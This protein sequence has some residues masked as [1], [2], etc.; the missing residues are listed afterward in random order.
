MKEQLRQHGFTLIEIMV[1]IAIIGILIAIIAPR[2]GTVRTQYYSR[3]E[4]RE[5]M[6]QFKKSKLE[7]VKRNRDVCIDF[8]LGG[9]SYQIFVNVDRDTNAPHTFDPINGDILLVNRPLKVTVLLLSTTFTNNQAGYNSRGL[10]LQAA[11]QNIVLG[12]GAAGSRSYTLAVS[13]TGNVRIQ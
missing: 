10:P 12:I 9:N 13:M 2:I 7:A 1:V 11:N 4:A 6:I 8:N 5:L 3:I